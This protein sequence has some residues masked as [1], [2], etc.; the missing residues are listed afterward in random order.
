MR[1]RVRAAVRDVDLPLALCA[2][3]LTA[4]G[5]VLVWSAT[6]STSGEAYLVRGGINAAL[7]VALGAAVTI[8]PHRKL[9]G[10]AP[11][12]YALS[13][14]LLLAV[15]SPLGSTINGSKSWVRL[16]GFS[17]Q[18]AE[19]AK[20]AL[21]VM[22]GAM[23]AGIRGAPTLRLL[24]NAGIVVAI[25][26]ALIMLQPD[27][28]SA[29]VLSALI[30]A[31]ALAARVRSAILWSA[32]GALVVLATIALTTPLLAGYQ[33]DRLTAFLH[34]QDDPGG[35]GYQVQ[36]VKVAIGA[37]GLFGEGLGHGHST[38]GGF[39]PFQ[40]TDFVF[41]VAGEELGFLG[42]GALV[43]LEACIVWRILVIARRTESDFGRIMCT[44]IAGWLAFQACENIG[45][46]LGMMPVTGVPLPFVSY[47]GSSL[48]AAWIAVGLAE[49]THLS[50]QSRI[51]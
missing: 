23:F 18:P 26:L 44:A 42:A 45:M 22:V 16:P 34:P 31:A 10:W 4:L 32:F 14:V 51:S 48:F 38:Q 50:A 43:A 13:V 6:R 20:V 5:V 12:M 30:W 33:R 35:I 41:S 17:L 49:N 40:Y 1:Q 46:N 15:L 3:I 36:Q 47:G 8:L 11:A 27:L 28:G 21:A 39:I 37:G 2:L 25:P 24:R 19:L 9:L 29:M 7:A